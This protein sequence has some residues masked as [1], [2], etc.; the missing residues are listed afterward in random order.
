MKHYFI[1]LLSIYSCSN[2]TNQST[3]IDIKLKYENEVHLKNIQQLTFGG[4]NA[5]AYWSFDDSKLVF[6]AKNTKWGAVCDQIYITGVKDHNMKDSIPK[7]ISTGFG[8]T[9]CSYFLPGD[10][11]V[12]YA[13]THLD[14]LNCPKLPEKRSDGKY[15]WPIYK[16]FDIFV[17]DLEGKIINQL[18]NND[19]YEL[20]A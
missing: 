20:L 4:D 17:S 3:N 7:L 8:R 19:G 11:S 1:L 16:S 14:N 15:V 5:E 10:T 9:T 13:S 2:K 12:I 6:Q 18:T